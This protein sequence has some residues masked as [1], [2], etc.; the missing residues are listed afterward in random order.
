VAAIPAAGLF[1]F[2]NVSVPEALDVGD[3]SGYTVPDV[4]PFYITN[5]TQ[6]GRIFLRNSF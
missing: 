6:V 1:W 5:D 4:W 3:D 2:S